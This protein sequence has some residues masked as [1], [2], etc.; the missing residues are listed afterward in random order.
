[1]INRKKSFIILV[2]ILI[3][4]GCLYVASNSADED[5]EKVLFTPPKIYMVDKKVHVRSADS[6]FSSKIGSLEI[7]SSISVKG[8]TSSNWY[9]VDYQGETGYVSSKQSAM[10]EYTPNNLHIENVTKE[11][12]SIEGLNST[13][14]FL[15]LTDNHLIVKSDNDDAKVKAESE[16]LTGFTNSSGIQSIESFPYWIE[17]ANN[18]NV[19]ALLM[20]GD[21]LA[22]PTPEGVAYMEKELENLK[23]SYVYSMGNHDWS[24]SW[25]YHTS[26]TYN[27]YMPLFDDLI[28]V[29][30]YKDLIVLSLD[31]STNQMNA[32]S[33]E[34]FQYYFD[35]GKP[36]ILLFHVPLSTE[37]VEA[38][39]VADWGWNITIG[40]NGLVPN[41]I[42]AAF[43]EKL[44][45]EDSPVV[46][47]LS[48]HIHAY[49]RSLLP[50]NI[51]QIVG[52]DGYGGNGVLLTV[53]PAE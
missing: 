29:L 13:Y 12:L 4:F 48:G 33:L 53:T 7:G 2:M 34:T 23:S 46:C 27:S 25:D 17:Y 39:S 18:M 9:V 32:Q 52:D 6:F 8:V 36:M 45:S 47:I 49:D 24:F 50:Q 38:K 28:S 31:N 11:Q 26:S 44:Y 40:A 22:Y 41:D 43:L 3:V 14:T 37:S 51:V 21:M 15:F 5:E 35:K 20:G 16:L 1:M 42:T 30:E 19:D 10:S